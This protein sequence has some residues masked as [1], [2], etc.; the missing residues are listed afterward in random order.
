MKIDFRYDCNLREEFK[1][2]KQNRN[3]TE[4]KKL[5]LARI[6]GNFLEESGAYYNYGA[7]TFTTYFIEELIKLLIKLGEKEEA[8]NIFKR[9]LGLPHLK[10]ENEIAFSLAIKRIYPQI[11]NQYIPDCKIKT[12]E[13]KVISKKGKQKFQG[14]SG[15]E[16]FVEEIAMEY[17]RHNGNWNGIWMNVT[18]QSSYFDRVRETIGSNKYEILRENVKKSMGHKCNL[19]YGAPDLFLYKGTSKKMGKAVEVKGPKD[20][21]SAAQLVWIEQFYLLGLDAE[22]LQVKEKK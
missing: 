7:Q 8:L 15:N 6:D 1:R 10:R 18:T 22:V 12:I 5:L 17:Y 14:T 16:L 20:K 9:G 2:L 21:L 3:Y 4:A 13:R 19:Y 11:A